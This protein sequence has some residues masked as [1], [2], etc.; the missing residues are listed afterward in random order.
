MKCRTLIM[1]TVAA[2][3]F[4]NGT[5]A[6]AQRRLDGNGNV[7]RYKNSKKG[8]GWVIHREPNKDGNSMIF[9][10]TF[11]R[12]KKDERFQG[13]S[14]H[15]A[16]RN[17]SAIMGIVANSLLSRRVEI[18]QHSSRRSAMQHIRQQYPVHQ[19]RTYAPRSIQSGLSHRLSGQIGGQIQHQPR[20]TSHK[21][22]RLIPSR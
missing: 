10:N 21:S 1:L 11:D 16:R 19:V 3:C 9:Q 7:L 6:Q 15:S 17:A 14:G 18:G 8:N 22:A 12:I 5:V 20:T 13:E 2:I 4:A